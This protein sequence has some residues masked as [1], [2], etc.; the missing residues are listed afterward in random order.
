LG[1]PFWWAS[2]LVIRKAATERGLPFGGLLYWYLQKQEPN[3][4]LFL[5]STT[6]FSYDDS[7]RFIC[8]RICLKCQQGESTRIYSIDRL[9]SAAC[10]YELKEG[11]PA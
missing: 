8:V 10:A 4:L 11:L 1:L 2:L 5:N 6:S 7:N 9:K 3:K